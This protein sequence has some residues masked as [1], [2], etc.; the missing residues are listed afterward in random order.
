MRLSTTTVTKDFLS[1]QS[2]MSFL[3]V[4]FEA[5]NIHFHNAGLRKL[6]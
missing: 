1:T 6:N 5:I 4:K 3:Q 2:G